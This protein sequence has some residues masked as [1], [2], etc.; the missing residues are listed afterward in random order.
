MNEITYSRKNEEIECV[1]YKNCRKNY[2]PHTHAS[3]LT[4]GCIEKGKICIVMDGESRIYES[5]EE[6]LIKPNV[7]H[8]IKTVDDSS[9]SMMVLCIKI[10]ADATKTNENL[11]TLQKAILENPE[12]I[13]LYR[14]NVKRC[15]NQSV[16]H[17]KK[18]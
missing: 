11:Q 3:H 13:Y 10:E 9:Y 8:E 18:V 14:R 12:N 5:G 7:L 1:I 2:K 15:W 17:D 16:P 6:F 4:V